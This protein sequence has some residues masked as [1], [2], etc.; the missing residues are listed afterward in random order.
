MAMPSRF[1]ANLPE[2]LAE[3]WIIEEDYEW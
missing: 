1:I 3:E 2:T